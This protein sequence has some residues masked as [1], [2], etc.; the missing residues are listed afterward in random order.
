MKI[1]GG[2]DVDAGRKLRPDNLVSRLLAEPGFVA[3][4]RRRSM[5]WI[6]AG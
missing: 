5:K 1:E 2:A 6:P 3:D 4:D